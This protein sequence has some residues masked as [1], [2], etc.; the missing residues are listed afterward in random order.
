MLFNIK[1]LFSTK[2]IAAKM[3]NI[4]DYLR[5]SQL[6]LPAAQLYK[7]YL[8]ICP[9]D[10][11][12]WIQLGHCQKEAGLLDEADVSYSRAAVLT[13][14]SGEI[15]L[16]VGHLR[17]LQERLPE[18]AASYTKALTKEPG[19][20]PALFELQH[21]RGISS[22]TGEANEASRL[23]GN[24]IGTPSRPA[25]V[26]KS[27]DSEHLAH[28]SQNEFVDT[29]RLDYLEGR[30]SHNAAQIEQLTDIYRQI[31]SVLDLAAT[32]KALG[33]A[34]KRHE[35][36]ADE[37]R[38]RLAKV[39]NSASWL[40]SEQGRAQLEPAGSGQI[41]LVADNNVERLDRLENHLGKS[42]KAADDAAPEI[43]RAIQLSPS[44]SNS[45]HAAHG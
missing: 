17:K 30:I 35:K 11:A 10:T 45:R 3:R 42:S 2:R 1:Y 44:S 16:Q 21:L 23:S 22:E 38:V 34:S 40:V 33:F 12:I 37:L 5:D 19:L 24:G 14:D 36:H 39:E 26:H 32:V 18:A 20:R 13:P 4:G 43:E 27:L 8:E 15:W 7:S 6:W 31:E 9:R 41:E 28:G 25:P 29:K